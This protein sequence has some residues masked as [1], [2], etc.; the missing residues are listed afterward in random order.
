MKYKFLIII[1]L[2]YVVN[3]YAEI[4]EDSSYNPQ[5]EPI[6]F[7]ELKESELALKEKRDKFERAKQLFEKNLISTEELGE[8]ETAFKSKEL[9]YQRKL[10]EVIFEKPHITILRAIK[11]QDQDQKKRVKIA[12]KN[13]QGSSLNL[14]KLKL[15]EEKYLGG[16]IDIAELKN[17]YVSIKEKGIIIGQPYE[18]KIEKLAIG[19]TETIDFM[20][21]KD[22]ESLT[23]S[24]NY[25]DKI[26]DNDIYLEK[27]SSANVV[28]INSL[29]FSQEADLGTRATYDLT[30]ERFSKE[31]TTF[32]LVVLNLPKEISYEFTDSESQA[33]LSQVKLIE[34]ATSKKLGLTLFLP[35]KSDQNV[36]ID[37]SIEFYALVV[38]TDIANNLED[39][40]YST[41]EIEKLK[42]GKVKLEL[43]PRGVGE[44]EVLAQNLYF[45]ITKGENVNMEVSIKNTGTRRL[46]NIK[47]ETELPSMWKSE[48]TPDLI[49]TLET[50]KN[51]E[52]K[53]AFFPNNNIAVGSYETKI[54]T[55]SIS[56][57]KRLESEDKIVR[58]HIKAKT[59]VLFSIFLVI[60][61]LGAIIGIVYYGITLTRR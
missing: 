48:I 16:N 18:R 46:D 3:L 12:L 7:L 24:V 47:I 52:I 29:Q 42:G 32:K 56:D 1:F 14:D 19:N 10:L 36:T 25:A 39:K 57:N 30:L 11:Y 5:S 40:N 59:N 50:G 4:K 37:K 53:I 15:L 31:D 41:E 54:K 28:L 38:T 55:N 60:I 23:V 21:L 34:G 26:E 9:Y 27:D 58:I 2:F 51:T 43:I 13:V 45:E 35:D 8:A 22:V 33:R 6:K 44:I 49:K 20:L 61:L 17:I